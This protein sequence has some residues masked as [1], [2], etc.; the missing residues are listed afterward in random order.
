MYVYPP[1]RSTLGVSCARAEGAAPS[2]TIIARNN[3][4]KIC[5]RRIVISLGIRL[6]PKISGPQT[7]SPHKICYCTTSLTVVVCVSVPD[8]P[9]TVMVELPAGVP[10]F[11]PA[12]GKPPEHALKYH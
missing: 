2:T 3:P 7:L 9:V 10:V 8:V 4:G 5:I 6:S 11:E 12:F 1:N